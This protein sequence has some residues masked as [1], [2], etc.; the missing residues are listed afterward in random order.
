MPPGRV[1]QR[2]HPD[3]TPSQE[4]IIPPPPNQSST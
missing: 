1:S 2:L 3:E 4:S